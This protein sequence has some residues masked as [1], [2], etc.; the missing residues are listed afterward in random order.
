MKLKD[1]MMDHGG[2]GETFERCLGVFYANDGMVGSQFAD[3][4]QHSMNVLVGLFRRYGLAA[5]VSKSR[6]I[7]FQPDAIR[8]GIYEEAKDLKCTGVGESYR[9]RLLRRIPCPECGVDITTG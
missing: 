1:H 8:S 7:T 6:T 2:L 3:W 5:N 4:L 9:V